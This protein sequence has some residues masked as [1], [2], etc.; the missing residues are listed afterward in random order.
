MKAITDYTGSSQTR[1]IIF[2]HVD[3]YK[4][5]RISTRQL[6]PILWVGLVPQAAEAQ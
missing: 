5:M 4:A 6:G 3:S 2:H 1:C